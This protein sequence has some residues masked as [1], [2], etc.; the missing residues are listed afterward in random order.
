MMPIVAFARLYALRHRIDHTHTL[1]R[2]EALSE[3]NI[4]LPSSR[5]EIIAAYDFLMQL[6]LQHQVAAIDN[7]HPPQNTIQPGKLGNIQN[8]LLKQA[9]AQISAVQKKVSYD[10]LGGV[11]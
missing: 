2:I 1:E 11:E 5:D 7:G 4:I 3:M 10:F 6:R 8:E 9:F